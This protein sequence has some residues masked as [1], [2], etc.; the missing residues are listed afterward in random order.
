MIDSYDAAA[1]YAVQLRDDFLASLAV[2]LSV[3]VAPRPD[4]QAGD[5]VEVGCPV[6]GGHVAYFP[7]RITSIRRSGSTVPSGTTLAV[8]CSYADVSAALARTDWAQFLGNGKPALTWDRMPGTWGSLPA[9]EWDS[10]PA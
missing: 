10:L 2:E 1:A 6:V 7:G 3:E 9:L 8:S 5:R 4:L